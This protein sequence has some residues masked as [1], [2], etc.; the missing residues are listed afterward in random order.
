MEAGMELL[1]ER[2][3]EPGRASITYRFNLIIE[4]SMMKELAA[5]LVVSEHT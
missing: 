2:S 4:E 1:S 5:W 3:T